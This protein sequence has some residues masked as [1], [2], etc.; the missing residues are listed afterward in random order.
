MVQLKHF[1]LPSEDMSGKIVNHV[2]TVAVRVLEV[3]VAKYNRRERLVLYQCIVVFGVI[4]VRTLFN[5]TDSCLLHEYKS[6]AEQKIS[7]AENFELKNIICYDPY[8][9]E[10]PHPSAVWRRT[11][12]SM[13][14]EFFI[15]YKSFSRS[16]SLEE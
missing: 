6:L 5:A 9:Y 16:N 2:Y 13:L 7:A 12:A 10:S 4:V 11:S 8:G 14:G 15:A 3:W 1:A